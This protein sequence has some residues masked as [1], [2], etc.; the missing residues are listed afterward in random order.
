L[1]I[2][3]KLLKDSKLKSSSLQSL[4]AMSKMQSVSPQLQQSV[5]QTAIV[6][7][8]SSSNYD[9]ELIDYELNEEDIEFVLANTGFSKEQISFWY[10]DFLSKCPNGFISKKQFCTYY[11]SLMPSNLNDKSKI[12]LTNKLFH[13]F[14]ID[15]D[16]H[17]NY[18]EFLVSFWIRCQAPL[19]EKYL[20]LFN[21]YDLDK[22]G[23]LD[24]NEIKVAL[25]CCFDVNLLDELLE[26]LN[27]ESN[28]FNPLPS[29]LPLKAYKKTTL[30]S[31][32]DDDDEA[33]YD[34]NSAF[35]SK[36]NFSTLNDSPVQQLQQQQ[37]M[38]VQQKLHHQQQQQPQ[39]SIYSSTVKLLDDKLNELI[40]QLDR[41]AK[42]MIIKEESPRSSPNQ[43]SCGLKRQ[44]SIPSYST[45]NI[46]NIFI[47]RKNFVNLCVKYKCLRKL[48][49]PIDY[50]Y[51]EF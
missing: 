15:G 48:L 51:E 25:K 12:N 26:Q 38:Q 1:I 4:S 32:T 49:I 28:I 23:V 19:R 17:L 45:S 7:S 35:S 46:K 40:L 3:E 43:E 34:D 44:I 37:H 8:K 24:Y 42:I 29:P 22:N 14:D 10:E 21:A 27:D 47:T 20:W 6:D 36:S 30:N 13:L 50:Y 11:K 33:F 9:D 2:T 31:S 5:S 39:Y 18:A 41:V 16:D